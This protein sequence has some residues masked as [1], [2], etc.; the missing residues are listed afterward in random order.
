MTRDILYA[1]RWLL[2]NPWFLVA[3][4]VILGLGVG[5]NTAV[6]SIVDAVLLRPL[7]YRS[8]S[9]LVSIAETNPK[10]VISFIPANDYF[11]WGSRS[12]LFE[13]TVPYRRDVVTLTNAGAPDQVSAVRTSAK[14]FSLLGVPSRLGRPLVDSD[15]APNAPAAAVLSDR[16]WRRVFH[17]EPGVI[18]RAITVSDEIFTIVGVMPP[19]FEFPVSNTEMWIPLR[20]NPGSS[21]ALQ[22]VAQL[23]EGLSLPQIQGAMQIV[24]GQLEQQDPKG[25]AG[26]RIQVS[27]WRETPDR[28][29]GLSLIFILSAVS[30]VLLIACAN[31]G[32]LLLSRAVQRQKEIAVRVSLGAGFWQIVRQQLAESMVLAVLASA[33]GIAAAY[34][35][36]QFL[37]KQL[38]ALP[39]VLPHIQRVALN[40]RVLLFN[41]VLC[42]FLACLCSLAPAIFAFRTDV[43]GVLRGG[44]ATGAP[45]STRLF[46]VL[47]ASEAALAC[48][49]LV[50]SGLLIRSLIRLQEADTGFRTDHVLTMRV[51]IG[52]LTQPRP[53]GKYDSKP[54]QIEFYRRVLDRLQGVPGVNAAAVVNNLPL[55][56]S[57]T[58][59]V[60]KASDGAPIAVMTRT[61]SSRY[62]AVMGT[63]L[64]KGR[65][66]SEADQADSP[67]V[68]I[69]NEYWARQL[70]PDRDPI[71]Q[72]LP[73]EDASRVQVVGVVKNS[74][75][76]GYDQPAK[77]E[78]YIPYRQF[79]F[80][81]FL[82]TIVV[83]T[84]VEPLALADTLRNE[85]WAVDA[86]E[87][88]LKVETMDE[89]IADSIWQPRFSAWIFSVLGGLAL[90]LTA[91]G[92]YGIVAYT[93]TLQ[94]REVGIRVALGASPER[95]IAVT[96][97]SA[98][99]PL[100][101]G[102]AISLVAA[103]ALARFLS[104]LLYEISSADPITYL[105]AAALV[106]AT[107]A[108]AS[109]RPAWK[110]AAGDP[111][112]ALRT[113]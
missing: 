5:A 30:L 88:I 104:S 51:P 70:F 39:L 71:G 14:L 91:V 109:A 19:E 32:S 111:L 75:Q 89:V 50:A 110:A 36:L 24:A 58:S 98:M 6:F 106:L 92:I 82:A 2:K 59:T 76:S 1:V 49:L 15:D 8:S 74:W 4:T 64:L 95:I 63:P 53:S 68:A 13:K 41:M 23:K 80:G 16:L 93:T 67:R 60:Y 45:G 78:V 96:L 108:V 40:G 81:T 35:V 61:I 52:T 47:I 79:I 100:S 42:L 55:S 99:I 21:V 44:Q 87:P 97:K 43:Q 48:L 86:N 102:L 3:V 66:F 113:E 7:P 46:S 90:L 26:L 28:K 94:A 37:L 65:V 29:Y 33:A 9:R 17:S 34:F 85:I 57:S 73:S 54:R 38:L 69:I 84:S 31:V 12:D 103:L 18:G 101:A 112:T 11:F 83:R 10:H 62:F 105:A 56:G 77:A 107:G 25:N 27:P 20:L 22:V 72:F